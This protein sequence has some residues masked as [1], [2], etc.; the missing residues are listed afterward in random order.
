[1][2][3]H[4]KILTAMIIGI[5]WALLSEDFQLLTSFN[6]KFL[7]PFGDIFMKLLNVIMIRRLTRL[8]I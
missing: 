3:L 5:F 6:I 4:W 7:A 2:A 8:I 1:M